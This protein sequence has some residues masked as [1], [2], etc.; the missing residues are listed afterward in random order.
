MWHTQQCISLCPPLI[1]VCDNKQMMKV[2]TCCVPPTLVD[3]HVHVTTRCLSKLYLKS[4]LFGCASSVF[5]II[6]Y[7]N[8]SKLIYQCIN[9]VCYT[10][11]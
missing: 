2:L 10:T 6:G 8:I 7:Q 3:V 5:K 1:K 11:S 9:L 4:K